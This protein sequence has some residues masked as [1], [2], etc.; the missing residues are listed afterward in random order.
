MSRTIVIAMSFAATVSAFA[1]ARMA[2]AKSSIMMS[3]P[4]G[5]VGALAPTGFFDPLG[6]ST[7]KDAATLKKYREAELKHG[8][9]AMLA[10]VGLLTQE[11]FDS[12]PFG[13]TGPAIYH[14]Q[15]VDDIF[16]LFWLCIATVIGWLEVGTINKVWE[17][18]SVTFGKTGAANLREDAEAGEYGFDPLG[19]YPSDASAQ[20]EIKT[21]ELQN[22]RLAMLSVLGIWVQELVDGKEILSHLP[23]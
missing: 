7:G 21:K 22:G 18:A 16:P 2:S 5:L 23:L 15:A 4:T 12:N 3:N 8:R 20:E 13:I 10:A 9:I 19:W 6:L 14:F 11:L 1:P 17:P